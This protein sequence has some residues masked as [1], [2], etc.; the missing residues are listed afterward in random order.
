MQQNLIHTPEGVRDIYG[1]EYAKKEAIMS[2]IHNQF[3]L[4]GYMDIETPTFEFFDVFS[5]K[6]GT[7][8]SRDLYKFFDKEGNTLV[9]RPDFTPSMARCASKYFMHEPLPVHFCYK[10]NTFT[11]TSNLQGKLKETTEMG[12]ELIGDS[13]IG[14]D[15]EMIG[16]LI[17]SIQAAGIEDF[18]ICIGQVEFF[19]GLCI[20]AGLDEDTQEQLRE[21][22]SNKNY[23][24]AEELLNEKNISEELKNVLLKVSDLFG[25]IES[26]IDA[27]KMVHNTRSKEALENL[28]QIYELLQEV[29]KEK[30]V[31][32]DLGMLSKYNYYTGIIYKAYTHGVGDAIGKGGRYDA[33]LKYFGKESPAIGFVLQI[34]TIYTATNRQLIQLPVEND[35]ILLLY[36]T[37]KKENYKEALILA[38]YL[39]NSGEKVQI[40]PSNSQILKNKEYATFSSSRMLKSILSIQEKKVIEYCVTTGVEN[41][42]ALDEKTGVKNE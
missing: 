2:A 13:S 1:I 30:Y 19:K 28:E 40:T 4:Y 27:K 35:I 9:L 14:A 5:K 33:L 8:P 26:I 32:F 42:Y 3:H 7:I 38:T 20:E 29:N 22:T 34:D 10:G 12:V 25:S 24:G 37:D 18:Q 21:Y 6:I 17:D 31:S 39:R 23:F 11:N 15:V 41:Q 16:L 36:D